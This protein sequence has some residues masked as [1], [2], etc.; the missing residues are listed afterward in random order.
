M[1]TF[2][3]HFDRL[4]EMA[5]SEDPNIRAEVPY[6][7]MR[8]ERQFKMRIT[9]LI[10]V[11]VDD[12]NSNV[13]LE[14]AKQGYALDKLAD[15]EN[16]EVRLAVA[17]NAARESR[18]D[19]LDELADDENETVRGVVARQGCALDKL[20]KDEDWYVRKCVAYGAHDTGRDDLLIELA[21]D[22]DQD[23]REAVARITHLK[24]LAGKIPDNLQDLVR[25]LYR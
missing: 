22:E 2:N 20:A 10:D 5:N 25:E 4:Y 17:R 16:W 18:I 7:A 6:N 9:D 11:L 23:V 24:P 3:K 13:R 8:V 1:F 14:I 12:K 15:D 19:L 21:G